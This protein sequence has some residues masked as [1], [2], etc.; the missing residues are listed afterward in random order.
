MTVRAKLFPLAALLA[1]AAARPAGATTIDLTTVGSGGM[2]N[3]ALYFQNNS[4]A[5]TGKFNPFLSLSASGQ[6]TVIQ[7]YNTMNAATGGKTGDNQDAVSIGPS[8]GNGNR[9]TELALTTLQMA[10]A[11][12]SLTGQTYYEVGVDVNTANSGSFSTIQLTQLKVYMSVDGNQS[13]VPTNTTNT[14]L[15]FDMS[16]GP[17]GTTNVISKNQNGSG[18]ADF[19]VA[20]PKADFDAAI[21]TRTDLLYVTYYAQFSNVSAGFQEIDRLTSAITIPTSVPEPTTIVLFVL[22]LGLLAHPGVR[23]R[24]A[25]RGP[26]PAS[27]EN[28]MAAAS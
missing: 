2:S 23:R 13:N 19:I 7:G 16:V 9:T 25:R 26:A 11:T 21:G 6:N 27:S 8:S 3:G 4:G 1:L 14:P 24:L 20:I 28:E 22:G 18:T 5:G 10:T 17:D 15:V 12:S